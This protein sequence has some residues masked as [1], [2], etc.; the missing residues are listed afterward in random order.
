MSKT[1]WKLDGHVDTVTVTFQADPPFEVVLDAAE[2]DDLLRNLGGL[3]AMMEPAHLLN[4]K[5]DGDINFIVDP[6]WEYDQ[7]TML[8][9]P[10][11]RIRDPRFGWLHYVITPDT[12][13]KLAAMLSGEPIPQPNPSSLN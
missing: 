3:R 13:K 5:K 7:E 9:Q 12:A 10:V 4:F 11:L 2:I 1:N 6:R 8:D